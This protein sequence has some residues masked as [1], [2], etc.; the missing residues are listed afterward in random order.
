MKTKTVGSRENKSPDLTLSRALKRNGAVGLFLLL[1]ALI[2]Y[3]LMP[4]TSVRAFNGATSRTV[5]IY[6][7]Y[8]GGGNSGATYTNDYVVLLNVSQSS[9]DI[10]GWSIQYQSNAGTTWTVV[11]VC[12]STTPGTCVLLSGHYWL[13]QLA[14]GGANGVALPVTPDRTATSL[15]ISATQGKMALVNST[16]S[17]PTTTGGNCGSV[18][19]VT[20]S[21]AVIDFVGW[22]TNSNPCSEGSPATGSLSNTQSLIRTSF[23]DTD[24]NASDFSINASPV[25]K[26]SASTPITPTAAEGG[27]TGRIVTEDG[28]GVGGA[29]VTLSGAEFRKTITDSS[30]R[31]QFDNVEAAGFYTLTPELANYT[32]SPHSRS[33]SQIG[34]QTDAV[35]KA[36]ADAIQTQNPLDTP[37]YFV[38]QQYLD[39]LG[40]EPDS[41]GLAYW[42]AKINAC[43]SDLACVRQERINVSAAFFMS[44]EFQQTGSFIYRLYKAGLG[45]EMSYQEFSQDHQRVVDNGALSASRTAFAASFVTRP[46]FLQKYNGANTAESFVDA[47]LRTMSQSSG[48]DLSSQRDALIASYRNGGSLDESRSRALRGAIVVESFRQSQLNSSFVLTEYFGYLHRDADTGGYQFWLDVLNNRVP[49][50]YRSMVCAFLTSSE[51]QRQFSTIVTHSNAECA[52]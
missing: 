33:F 4:A 34:N 3:S 42:S 50:N 46:E 45:R 20:G 36:S 26:N 40:R 32:F 24:N 10:S 23:I 13:I 37:E 47:L 8:P 27:I 9:I 41:G 31:Y 21:P 12:S 35:F 52:Q 18:L 38:R 1:F 48:V 49:G 22:G 2:A 7:L 39:F 11:N 28:A 29:I 5:E 6:E 19:S 30:G 17:L 51:Y 44:D 15:N 16:T 43:G 25:P 14:S